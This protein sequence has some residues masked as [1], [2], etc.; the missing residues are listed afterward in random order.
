MLLNILEQLGASRYEDLISAMTGKPAVYTT[1]SVTLTFQQ[2]ISKGENDSRLREKFPDLNEDIVN[3]MKAASLAAIQSA[4]QNH[5]LESAPL[6]P[7]ILYRWKEWGDKEECSAWV[8]ST[9]LKTPRSAIS[10]LSKFMHKVQSFGSGDRIARVTN[11]IGLKSVAEFV[12]LRK[13]AELVRSSSDTELTPDEREAKQLF[14]KG[15]QR[16]DS[17]ETLDSIDSPVNLD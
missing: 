7:T 12:D 6:L 11:R 3:R 2:A 4:A 8:E 15:M 1:V 17:G 10:F 13:F 16:L 14:L 5:E 9:F